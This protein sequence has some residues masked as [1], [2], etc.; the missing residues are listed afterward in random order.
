VDANVDS[1]TV[2]LL[3]LDS[4]NVDDEFLS[5]ALHDL[6]GLLALVVTTDNL[7]KY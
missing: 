6:A 7:K 3:T 5:V 1:G 2:G 4:L